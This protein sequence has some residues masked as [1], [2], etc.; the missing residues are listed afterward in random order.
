MLTNAYAASDGEMLCHRFK[1]LGIGPLIGTR[2]WGGLIG[3]QPKAP[4]V[5]NT[6]TTQPEHAAW[7]F[8]VGFGLEN[9]G[10]DPDVL[11]ECAPSP[12]ELVHDEQLRE[13]LRRALDH[14][15]DPGPEPHRT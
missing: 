8:D 5:D 12:R 15:D 13:S 7:F 6:E 9:H 10:V 2:T 3:I 4:L 14:L 1:Q 11:V